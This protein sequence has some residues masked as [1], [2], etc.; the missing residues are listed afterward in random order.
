MKALR[1]PENF[2]LDA[3][4]FFV[5]TVIIVA[6][7]FFSKYTFHEKGIIFVLLESILSFFPHHKPPHRKGLDF[8]DLANVLLYSKAYV[9]QKELTCGGQAQ[10]Q[11]QTIFLSKKQYSH[12]LLLPLPRQI[13]QLPLFLNTKANE[14]PDNHHFVTK[15]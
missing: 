8:N 3:S 2:F 1:L 15:Q 11:F 6:H 4:I 13:F 5:K 12:I 10:K 9:F 14:Y 7:H